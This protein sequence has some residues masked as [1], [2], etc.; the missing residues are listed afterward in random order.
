MAILL[1]HRTSGVITLEPGTAE[2]YAL[3]HGFAVAPA[4]L[5]GDDCVKLL[6]TGEWVATARPVV[7]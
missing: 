7:L 3:D 5:D 4:I 1:L 6:R 2:E